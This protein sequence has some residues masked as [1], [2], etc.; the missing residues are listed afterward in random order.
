MWHTP[1]QEDNDKQL[2]GIKASRGPAFTVSETNKRNILPG[3]KLI[4]FILLLLGQSTV[5]FT[6]TEL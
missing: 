1:Q 3:R 6:L 2:K 5:K 4:H